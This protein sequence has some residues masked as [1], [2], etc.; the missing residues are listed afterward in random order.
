[1]KH[2]T[3]DM[4]KIASLFE[5]MRSAGLNLQEDFKEML[6]LTHLPD[7]YFQ[8]CSTLIQTVAEPDFTCDLITT[9]INAE[10]NMCSSHSLS[11]CISEVQVF[12]HSSNQTI[13]I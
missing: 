11:S 10:L 8:F 13:A 2:A 7:D 4:A 6:L 1:M 3:E 5:D 12:E 9:H